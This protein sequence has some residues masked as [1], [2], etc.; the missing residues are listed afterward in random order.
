MPRLSH[1]S[2]RL[3]RI[4]AERER[5]W[6]WFSRICFTVNKTID[7]APRARPAPYAEEKPTR[8]AHQIGIGIGIDMASGPDWSAAFGLDRAGKVV[9]EREWKHE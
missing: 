2:R 1:R 8:S 6:F 4:A 3:R 9:F 7:S 5:Q